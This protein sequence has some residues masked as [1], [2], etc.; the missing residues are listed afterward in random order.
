MIAKYKDFTIKDN[1][2]ELVI[3]QGN[4]TYLLII[5][6]DDID[7]VV[8]NPIFVYNTGYCMIYI[9]NFTDRRKHTTRYTLHSVIL[10]R[11][12]NYDNNVC[13]HINGN[14]LDNRKS[15][16]RIVSRSINRMNSKSKGYYFDK[17]KN[18]WRAYIKINGHMRYF[19]CNT[20]LEAKNLRQKFLS[21]HY[22]KYHFSR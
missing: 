1:V 6:K 10:K 21:Y 9:T 8:G 7:I 5:D 12:N 22:N 15:N 13:D 4:K 16:L 14:K 19:Q 2:A 20:E 18:K 3:K 17:T 11:N